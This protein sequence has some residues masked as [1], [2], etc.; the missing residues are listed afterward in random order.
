M[1]EKVRVPV[2]AG[3]TF[4]YPGTTDNNLREVGYYFLTHHY[5]ND[6]GL[7]KSTKSKTVFI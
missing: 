2:F 4:T 3:M 5:S 7:I 6:G 1:K